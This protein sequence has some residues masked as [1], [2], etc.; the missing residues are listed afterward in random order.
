MGHGNPEEW[1]RILGRVAELDLSVVVPGHG[2]VGT[3]DAFADEVRYIETMQQIVKDALASGKMPEEAMATPMPAAF[4]N[5]SWPE[6]FGY[7]IQALMER[8]TTEP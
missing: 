1:V 7:N 3:P 4:A 6:G 8:H 5:W 2:P